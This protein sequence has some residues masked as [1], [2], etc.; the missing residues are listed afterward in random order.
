MVSVHYSKTQT[1]NLTKDF[2]RIIRILIEQRGLNLCLRPSYTHR[3]LTPFMSSKENL[4]SAN[5]S[6]KVTNV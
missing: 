1:F 6:Q 3:G 5:C 2:N 4:K